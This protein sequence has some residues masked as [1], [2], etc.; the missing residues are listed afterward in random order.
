MLFCWCLVR[1]RWK[2]GSWTSETYDALSA[3]LQDKSNRGGYAVFD[4]DNTSIVH[5]ITHNLTIYMVENLR[6]A[7]APEHS[8]LDGRYFAQPVK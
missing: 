8:F 1:P 3:L 2:G 4:C 5:D 7:D 6:F